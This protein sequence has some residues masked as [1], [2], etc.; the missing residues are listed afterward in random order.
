M[1]LVPSHLD[2]QAATRGRQRTAVLVPAI[3]FPAVLLAGQAWGA[4]QAEAG[5]QLTQRWCRSCHVVDTAGHGTDAAPPFSVIAAKPHADHSWL[6]AWLSSPHPRM[7][8]VHLSNE[9][10]GDIVAY[11]NSLAQQ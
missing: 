1:T 11:L 2:R 10:I 6:S 4:G 8:E 3:I 7:P 9:E 5:L